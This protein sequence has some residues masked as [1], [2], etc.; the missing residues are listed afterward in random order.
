VP[1]ILS[2]GLA[3]ALYPQLLAVVV[4]ILTR[5]NPLRLL[6]ACYLGG[7]AMTLGCSA[8]V[9]LA[10]RS[11]ESIAGSNSRGLGSGTYLIAGLIGLLFAA[12]VATPAGRDLLDRARPRMP[13]RLRKRTPG[14]E[15]QDKRQSRTER[16]LERGSIAVATGVGAILGIPGPF[17]LLA[18]GHLARSDYGPILVI[19]AIAAFTLI[20]FLLIELPILSYIVEPDVT[21]AR[22]ARFAAWLKR[23]KIELL[24]GIVGVVAV[25]LIVRGISGLT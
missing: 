3:A 18:L 7:A 20:K 1:T 24:A 21:A 4:V 19:T 6:W 2:L 5:P 9:L 12:L 16:L 13:A 14:S 23:R 15:G 8:G 22:V 17:D 10:F 25:V 11:H